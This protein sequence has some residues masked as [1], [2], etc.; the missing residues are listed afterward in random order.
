MT[1]GWVRREM[2]WQW[3][4]GEGEMEEMCTNMGSP[5]RGHCLPCTDRARTGA[6]ILWV[7]TAE[8][9]LFGLLIPDMFLGHFAQWSF[10][11]KCPTS[12]VLSLGP[13]LWAGTCGNTQTFYSGS[14]IISKGRLCEG[15]CFVV[16]TSGVAV[17]PGTVSGRPVGD[18]P[19]CLG[20][21]LAE[22]AI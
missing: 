2:E 6:W 20:C 22:W 3:G 17:F 10:R 14:F 12:L 1:N 19:P 5:C 4:S 11:S 8:P 13:I 21:W 18:S 7:G 16:S 9:T 15:N